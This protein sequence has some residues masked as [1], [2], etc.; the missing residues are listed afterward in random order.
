MARNKRL[1]KREGVWWCWGYDS[2]GKRY[3]KSTKQTDQRA[4]QIVA[5]EIARQVALGEADKAENAPLAPYLERLRQQKLDDKRS[6]ETIEALDFRGRHLV[7]LLGADYNIAGLR[8]EYA[9]RKTSQTKLE[10]YRDIRREEGAKDTTIEKELR[11]IREICRE[12]GFPW[13]SRWMPVSGESQPGTRWLTPDEYNLLCANLAADRRDYVTM[14]CFTGFDREPLYRLE[15]NHIDLSNDRVWC[16]DRKTRK[17]PRWVPLSPETREVLIRRMALPGRLFEPWPQ[18]NRDLKRAAKRAGIQYASPKDMRR[19]FASWLG[20]A[21]Y[22][23]E[24]AADLM[25]NSVAVVSKIY[26]RLGIKIRKDAVQSLSR[27]VGQT[28]TK[29]VT[30]TYR[31]DETKAP[32]V[33]V[34]D[35]K[36]GEKTL[37]N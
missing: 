10:R 27:W 22:T 23:A 15:R 19:T 11:H 9:G 34:W 29:N 17:R 33:N 8:E 25:G 4:A 7:R 31:T 35:T 28:E 18:V 26:M 16:D 37:T 2:K 3:R 24:V 30:D 32:T 5:I 21:G 12:Y 14:W 36:I 20:N 6:P 1:Y 13:N